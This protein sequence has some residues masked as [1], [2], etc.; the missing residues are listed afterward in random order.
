MT[1][2]WFNLATR[3]LVI[4]CLLAC[5]ARQV[6]AT[7]FILGEACLLGLRGL[8]AVA[9]QRLTDLGASEALDRVRGFC[10]FIVSHTV[11][12][13]AM[14]NIDQIRQLVR[15]LGTGLSSTL[16]G[17]LPELA[18]RLIDISSALDLSDTFDLDDNDGR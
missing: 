14:E 6:E 5:C 7:F 18:D 10:Q 12:G 2:K 15:L 11:E 4:G 9:Q 1:G 8:D 13:Y 3:L 17:R 16:T